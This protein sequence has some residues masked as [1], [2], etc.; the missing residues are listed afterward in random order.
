MYVTAC[1]QGVGQD[2]VHHHFVWHTCNAKLFYFFFSV[3]EG[4]FALSVCPE[5]YP[6]LKD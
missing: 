3:K 2:N 5:K 1:V 6:P 4:C